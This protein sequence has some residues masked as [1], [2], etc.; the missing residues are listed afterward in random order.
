[1]SHLYIDVLCAQTEQSELLD[2]AEAVVAISSALGP[3]WKWTRLD[4]GRGP[5]NEFDVRFYDAMAS[6]DTRLS[7]EEIKSIL[8][9]CASRGLR[10]CSV[11][12]LGRHTVDEG[13][14]YPRIDLYCL[15]VPRSKPDDLK[16][17][18][19]RKLHILIEPANLFHSRRLIGGKWVDNDEPWVD[20][21]ME[22]FMSIARRVQPRTM[23]M[24][25]AEEWAL[26]INSHFAYF[27]SPQEV[28]EDIKLLRM[29][30]AKGMHFTTP[31]TLAIGGPEGFRELMS[32]SPYRDQDASE[33]VTKQFSTAF[34]QRESVTDEDVH[35]SIQSKRFDTLTP[36]TFP[37]ACFAIT[38]YP[39]FLEGWIE[40]FYLDVLGY[41][42][43]EEV[44]TSQEA[45]TP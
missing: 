13:E 18:L 39:W 25:F 41:R 11:D 40:H 44:K 28:I 17:R 15:E 10:R 26:P 23:H 12:T 7:A 20:W 45:G 43:W 38:D 16:G 5:T 21:L 14:Q 36:E 19:D 30:W 37:G 1:M 35:R 32:L 29:V 2:A 42:W 8:L 24:Y 3:E 9:R 31:P 34:G 6:N 4:A 27:A 22:I 33:L